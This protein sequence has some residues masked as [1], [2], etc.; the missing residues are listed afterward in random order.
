MPV[1]GTKVEIA[2]DA[3]NQVG[4][5]PVWD[6]D[7]QALYWV[8]I[9]GKS[10]YRHDPSS[11]D[12]QQWRTDDFPTAIALVENQDNAILALASGVHQFDFAGSM[13]LF[14]TPDERP[15][16]RLNEGKCD[17][18]GRF[19][20]GSMQTNLNADGTGRDITA[21]SGALFRV[22]ADGGS[23]RLS[24]FE[25]GIS[26]TMVWSRDE[27]HFYF[28]D[29]LRNVLLRYDYDRDTGRVDN[30]QV[31]FERNDLGFPDGSCI[32]DDGCLWNAR[33][34]AGKL[35][36]ITP[37]GKVDREIDLPVTNPTS[38]TFG[39]SDGHTLYVTSA[40]F[41]LGD[42]AIAANPTEGALLALD[43]GASGPADRR[44]AGQSC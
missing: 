3:Q 11:A 27:R 21:H 17:P 35:I 24:D 44:F 1:T 15:G 37:Q 18:A 40:R 12:L 41:S 33:F 14:A 23:E 4:E 29:S 8:D 9:I 42:E 2:L 26:N 30:R 22:D 32:D 20:V 6:A 38:C 25:F 36:R 7:Q 19:W 43:V 5:S 10:I 28:G 34:S 31:F 13:T 39:G 16:N